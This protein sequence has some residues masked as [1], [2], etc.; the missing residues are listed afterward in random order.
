MLGI[1]RR[2]LL[3]YTCWVRL[4]ASVLGQG[5]LC[6]LLCNF[7]KVE[8]ARSNSRLTFSPSGPA[9]AR[10]LEQGSM[11]PLSSMM[12]QYFIIIELIYFCC[13]S[14]VNRIKVKKKKE[15]FFGFRFSFLLGGSMLSDEDLSWSYR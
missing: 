10:Q 5:I 6:T 1:D 12:M 8:I 15:V 11:P 7:C 3:S 2:V 14:L 9:A 13:F 4:V